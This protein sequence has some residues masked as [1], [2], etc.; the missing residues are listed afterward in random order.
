VRA[1]AR[2]AS[3]A[4]TA[5]AVDV[6][7]DETPGAFYPGLT[8]SLYG[9]S[10]SGKSLIAQW[11]VVEQLAAGQRVLYVDFESTADQIVPRLVALAAGYGIDLPALRELIARLDYVNPQGRITQTFI[12]GYLTPGRYAMAIVDGVTASISMWGA[13]SNS[14]DEFTTWHH[15][16]PER[17]ARMTG[18]AVIVIDHVGKT[19]AQN[20]G[21][22]FAIG[23][24][25]KMAVLTGAAYLVDVKRPFAPGR[26]GEVIMQVAKDRPG[27]VRAHAGE[28]AAN[29]LQPWACVTVDGAKDGTKIT[30]TIEPVDDDEGLDD[31]PGL[32]SFD[33]P[34]WKDVAVPDEVSRELKGKGSGR[35]SDVVRVLWAVGTEDGLTE[36]AVRAAWAEGQGDMGKNASSRWREAWACAMRSKGLAHGSGG[37]SRWTLAN[38][39]EAMLERHNVRP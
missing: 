27:D 22:R 15:D 5:A 32:G 23:S 2:E 21:S 17:I 35:A 6:D 38:H 14:G 18:A 10:E 11:A 26:A 36:A 7:L 37:A 8:H 39:F 30:L 29:R 16:L 34:N 20:G 4:M 28:V 25:A 33:V 1:Q 19:N 24:Q 12:D 3:D 31:L 9:E 13:K